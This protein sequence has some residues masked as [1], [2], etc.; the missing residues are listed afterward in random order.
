M[1]LEKQFNQATIFRSFRDFANSLPDNASRGLFYQMIIDY[2]LDAIEPVDDGS[3]IYNAFILIK[4]NIDKSNIK[5]INGSRIKDVGSRRERTNQQLNNNQTESKT[6]ANQQ[7]NNIKYPTTAQ[8]V[9]D[10]AHDQ[11][12]KP[13]TQEMAELY[14]SSRQS[15][16][17]QK[18]GNVIKNIVADIAGY[19]LNYQQGQKQNKTSNENSNNQ[20]EEKANPSW[21]QEDHER[22]KQE[23]AEKQGR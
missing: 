1:D 13:F 19:Y 5:R 6:E 21:W 12:K 15:T 20:T 10:I 22:Y 8:E 4:P 7:L 2:S 11:A 3:L 17:W 16:A 23:M 18:R 9:L 14:L